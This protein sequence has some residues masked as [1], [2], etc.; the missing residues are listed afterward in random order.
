MEFRISSIS[1][2]ESTE[3]VSVCIC[4]SLAV[5]PEVVEFWNDVDFGGWLKVF[6]LLS[7]SISLE[8]VP[9]NVWLTLLFRIVFLFD[10]LVDD[11]GA[12]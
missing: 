10:R 1:E 3:M 8:T 9:S 5:F 6:C 7:L 12:L 2:T 4:S 11:G